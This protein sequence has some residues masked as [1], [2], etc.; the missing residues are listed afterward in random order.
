MKSEFLIVHKK[1]LPEY[2]EKVIEARQLLESREVKTVT[3][4]VQR[5]G[6]SRNTYYKYKDYIFPY[7]GTG[8][9]RQAILSFQLKDTPGALS[10][11]ITAMTSHACSI[12]TISQSIPVTGQADVLVSL[13]ISD[14]DTSMEDLLGECRALAAVNSVHLDAME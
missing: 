12:L 1:I 6:I 8:N 3:E 4:A 10:S 7:D 11:L 13:D 2:F 9:R 14:I 5:T